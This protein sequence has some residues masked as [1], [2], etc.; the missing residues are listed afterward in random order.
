MTYGCPRLTLSACSTDDA[1]LGYLKQRDAGASLRLP[2]TRYYLSSYWSQCRAVQLLRPVLNKLA[3]H[4][5]SDLCSVYSCLV[6]DQVLSSRKKGLFACRGADSCPLYGLPDSLH[7][8]V[9]RCPPGQA[10][11]ILGRCNAPLRIRIRSGEGVSPGLHSL[12]GCVLTFL[13]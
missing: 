12:S 4:R 7:Y 9:L 13:P 3:G 11:R 10:Q 1:A 8:A 5:S 2:E 6:W